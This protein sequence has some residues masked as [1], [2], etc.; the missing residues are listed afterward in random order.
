MTQPALDLPLLDIHQAVAPSWWPPAPGWWMLA[1]AIVLLLAAL[2]GWH[3]RRTRHRR[4]IVKLFD[5]TVA[6]AQT[7]AAQ[8]AAISELL[9]RAARREQ[10]DADVLQG[11]AWLQLLDRGMRR[12]KFSDGAG[13]ILL[14]G[15]Y[16]RDV[17]VDDIARLQ[18]LAR[19]RFLRWM[20]AA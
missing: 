19:Q 18:P 16:R 8:L 13:R 15:L 12:E 11:D 10:A 20:G 9:R 17:S 4:A 7:P 1:A 3:W 6:A 5:E 14:D 2:G